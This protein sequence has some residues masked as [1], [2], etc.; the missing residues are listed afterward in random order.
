MPPQEQIRLKRVLAT[1]L[2]QLQ[3]TARHIAEVS[4]ECKVEVL[5]DEYIQSF[6]PILMDVIHAWSKVRPASLSI[7]ASLTLNHIP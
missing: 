1:P 4:N 5:E 2:Q 7:L 3:E 6:Q